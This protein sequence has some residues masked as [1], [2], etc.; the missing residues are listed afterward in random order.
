MFIS[1]HWTSQF[2]QG[3]RKTQP[4][5]TGHHVQQ[6]ALTFV[7]HDGLPDPE[8]LDVVAGAEHAL[9]VRLHKHNRILKIIYTYRVAKDVLEKLL[10][11]FGC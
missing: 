11:V 7:V 4:C 6:D 9:V 2:L 5:L 10:F 3:A 1:V 8:G